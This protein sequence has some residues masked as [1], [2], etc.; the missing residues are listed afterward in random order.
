M[1]APDRPGQPA[2]P[3]EPEPVA[4]RV[5]I[6]SAD[7]GG[8]HD[9]TGR[10]L[11]ERT[12]TLWPGSPVGWVDT[13]DVMGPGVGRGFRRIYVTN[14][15]STP[16]LYEFF[17]S[18][19]WRH[20]WFAESSKWFT[21]VWAGRRLAPVVERFD[22][23][24][25]LSTYPL[26]S[27]GLAWLRR[28]RGLGVPIGAWVSDFAP[29]PSWV[30][31]QLDLNLVVHPAALPV[32]AVAAPGAPL[33]ACAAPVLE[34]FRPGDGADAARR[35][36]LDPGRERVVV[37]CGSYGFGAV[38]EAIRALVDIGDAVQVVA[39]CG[40][41]E[42][43]AARL[44]RLPAPPGRLLVRRWVDDMPT[45]LRAAHLL[46]TNAGGATALEA[47]ATGTPIVM[48]RPIAAHGTANAA[49]MAY[50][51]LA[52]TAR[53]PAALVACVRSRLAGRR[54]PRPLNAPDHPS[55][56]DLGLPAVAGTRP[57]P[58]RHA[59]ARRPAS[60]PLRPQDAFFRYVQSPTVAQQIGVVLE[61]GPRPDGRPLTGGDLAALLARRLPAITTLRRRLVSRGPWRR[62]G[63]VVDRYVDP[64]AHL[65]EIQ[66]EP[67]DDGTDAV[68]RFWS[69]P[70]ALD[71][72]LWRILL[73]GGLP[74]GRARVAVKLHHCLADGLSAV[75]VLQRLLDAADARPAGSGTAGPRTAGS[76]RRWSGAGG[77]E[78][79]RRAALTAAGLARL[80]LRGPAPRSALN[81]LPRSPGRRL[82]SVT[83]PAAEVLRAA[84]ACQAHASELV[85]A[86]T[87]G[88]LGEAH[89]APVPPRM[90]AMFAVTRDPR[91]RAPTQGNWTGA[92]TLDLPLGP[93]PPRTRVGTVREL[94][95]TALRSGQAEAA[96]LVMR[97]AGVLPAP[98]HA[99]FARRVY[100]RRHL[101]VIVSYVPAPFRPQ[102]LAGAPIRT[103]TPVVALADGV[104]VGVGVLRC[105]AT[106]EVG[107]LLDGSLAAFGDRLAAAL[108]AALADLL[109]EVDGAPLD[110]DEA[111]ADECTAGTRLL[112]EAGLRAAAA[113]PPG[114]SPCG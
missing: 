49:L 3:T 55:L 82:R 18:S 19:L 51:G 77:R 27:A 109:A 59:S 43:L 90:R 83:L 85:L 26:G 20:R 110:L 100:T 111:V 38:E 16:W 47:W 60:W 84:R 17:W 13:L 37:A 22:P 98:L 25:I 102:L 71:R 56:P 62:P 39:V 93:V 80:A 30:Y 10:A 32:A 21:G 89:P 107:V 69:Q 46:V 99:A 40:R 78:A 45:L 70:L 50:A 42:P 64:A 73:V 79:A 24:L 94:L 74:D 81:A 106:F 101:N 1:T 6:I 53:T 57:A 9:A 52:E 33:A 31:P 61:L 14:V 103:A 28:H 12:R 67:G 66:V 76:V 86:L 97:A 34:R 92:V 29:H 5:L 54:P 35:C 63:W 23:D 72:P 58:D 65:D 113:V 91:R 112:D 36:G 4:R 88:A 114:V 95:R 68:D 15:G 108:P 44:S 41:N 105:G 7:I 96:G 8:G 75:G 104:P 48:Y 11:E 2:N 87:A